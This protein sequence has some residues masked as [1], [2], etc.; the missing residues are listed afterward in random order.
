[1]RIRQIAM[2]HSADGRTTRV[3]LS[4]AP[5]V[6]GREPGPGGLAIADREISRKHAVFEPAGEPGAAGWR[7]TDLGS[8]NG[9]VVDGAPT[10]AAE[11]RHGSVV[12]IGGAVLVFVDQELGRSPL[13]AP[14]SELLR[15]ASP[16]MQLLRGE[17]AQVARRPLAVIVGGESGA[18]K[19]RVAREI[20]R[21]SGRTG[22]LVAVN[23]AAIA[24]ELAESEL[25]G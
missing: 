23:C 16:I 21:L 20:H 4:A 17:L 5:V 11:L 9:I 14:E 10:A 19:E 15:G 22:Q 2:V 25:F 3:T 1:M 12:R 6:V 18:G 7:V 13:L 24:P 8:R